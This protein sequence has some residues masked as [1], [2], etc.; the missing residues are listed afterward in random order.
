M[1]KR[2]FSLLLAVVM[3]LGLLP[4]SVLAEEAC[5]HETVDAVCTD[6]A[7]KTHAVSYVCADCGEQTAG[8]EDAVVVD[9]MDF[10]KNAPQQDWWAGLQDSS[11]EGVKVQGSFVDATVTEE[12]TAAYN[13]MNAWL[14]ENT[15]W[16]ID[17][18]N[19]SFT[20]SGRLKNFYINSNAEANWGIRFVT[21]YQTWGVPYSEMLLKVV[22]P[23]A[24]T[25]DMSVA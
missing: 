15:C 3:L 7:D 2:I 21:Y 10:A 9:F 24:G 5:V 1:K 23:A 20:N 16:S 25:Y 14:A 11:T 13:A 8:I 12:Y 18:S 19:S 4:M 22:V 17:E 6:N